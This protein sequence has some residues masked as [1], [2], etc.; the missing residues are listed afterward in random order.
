MPAPSSPRIGLALGGGGARG[1]AH[2]HVLEALDDLGLKAAAVTGTSIGSIVGAGYCAGL[3]GAEVREIVL[4]AFRRPGDVWAKMW[5]LRPK[6]IADLLGGGLVQFD[7]E[8]VLGMFLPPDLP[9]TFADLEIPLA[10]V[11]ADFYRCTE[12]EI[13]SGPLRPAIAASIAL[14]IVF[15]PVEIG[16]IAMIDGGVVNPLPFDKLPADMDLVVAVDVVGGPVRP[17]ARSYPNARESIF[18]ASQI[19]MQTVIAEKLKSRTPDVLVR[20]PV[21]IFGVLDFL[22]ANAILKSTAPVRDEVKRKIEA[23]LEH[24]QLPMLPETGAVT[25]AP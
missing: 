12:V 4:D 14:P 9:A 19:L 22:K 10:V 2:V 16:G 21:D 5:Q 1:L 8:T 24:R 15:K 11:A 6:R 25:V 17:S 18:G 13:A 20:P 3:S 7:P 23:A